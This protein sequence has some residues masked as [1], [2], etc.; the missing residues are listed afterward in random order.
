MISVRIS[1]G[2]H[3]G[4]GQ[5]SN[6]VLPAA[7]S[8]AFC[9]QAFQKHFLLKSV[10]EK[11]Y[12]AGNPA[13]SANKMSSLLLPSIA[14]PVDGVPHFFTSLVEEW[15]RHYGSIPAYSFVEVMVIF[16]HPLSRSE[17]M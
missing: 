8:M 2:E 10:P 9:P 4:K 3:V 1:I 14:N 11:E 6:Q 12:K 17:M 16:S 13:W 7:P 15:L 5:S